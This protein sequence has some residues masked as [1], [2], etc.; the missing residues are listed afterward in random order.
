MSYVR[1]LCYFY[2]GIFGAVWHQGG[3]DCQQ[4]TSPASDGITVNCWQMCCM[5]PST[6]ILTI[7][8][9]YHCSTSVLKLRAILTKRFSP[10]TPRQLKTTHLLKNKRA[11][12]TT[13]VNLSVF[14]CEDFRHFK[15]IL[16][17]HS[18]FANDSVQCCR[19][20]Y[21]TSLCST[22]FKLCIQQLFKELTTRQ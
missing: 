13:A 17:Y 2:L 9:L 10:A 22:L 15:A 20:T 1:L 6:D 5:L 16:L 18:S 8:L 21:G 19:D 11:L 7:C 4:G 3:G 14:G 12:F